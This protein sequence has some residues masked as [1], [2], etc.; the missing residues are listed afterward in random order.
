MEVPTA[1]T[2]AQNRVQEAMLGLKSSKGY[3]EAFG[4]RGGAWRSCRG[5]GMRLRTKGAGAAYLQRGGPVLGLR[6]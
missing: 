1:A 6:G 3:T 4:Q 2:V 5:R